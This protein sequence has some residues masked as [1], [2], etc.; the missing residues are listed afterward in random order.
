M[1]PYPTGYSLLIRDVARS[2]SS[3][4]ML[5]FVTICCLAHQASISARL[6][7]QARTTNRSNGG[8]ARIVELGL[9][10]K[11]AQMLRMG[12]PKL[13]KGE[14]RRKL[15]G[16][17]GETADASGRKGKFIMWDKKR[18]IPRTTILD[19]S[20]EEVSYLTSLSRFIEPSLPTLSINM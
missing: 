6:F 9:G 1:L 2:G 18:E 13:E 11:H 19:T 10:L 20:L 5:S 15:V 8:Q 14:K 12:W 17:V 7:A 16:F 4:H 3:P